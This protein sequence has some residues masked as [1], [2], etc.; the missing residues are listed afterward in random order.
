MTRAD[1]VLVARAFLG[2]PFHHQGRLPGVG[3]DCAGV[4][5]C[6]LTQLG[7]QVEDQT[8]YGRI[9]FQGLLTHAIE[10][11]CDPIDL[12]EANLG[13]LMLF[14]FRSDPQHIAIISMLDPIMLI[15]AYQD[16]HRVVETGL[17]ATWESRLR[18]CYR[19]RGLA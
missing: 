12:E 4:V 11:H 8:G 17:D 1:F 16:V 18:G 5:V 19:V 3:L 9:P 10:D 6:A 2:T 13:D 7:Y 15:H 14:A